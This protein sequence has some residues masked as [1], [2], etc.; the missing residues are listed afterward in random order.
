LIAM[1][2]SEATA[3]LRELEEMLHHCHNENDISS[4]IELRQAREAVIAVARDI[5]AERFSPEPFEELRHH[6]SSLMLHEPHRFQ[7][8]LERLREVMT[9]S[10]ASEGVS[11]APQP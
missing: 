9:T 11:T 4:G 8:T 5:K 1:N 2:K 7:Q 6:V 3:L 10:R